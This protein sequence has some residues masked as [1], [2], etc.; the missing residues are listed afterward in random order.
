MRKSVIVAILVIAVLTLFFAA[1]NG[2]NS[3]TGLQTIDL[4][5]P[6]P[7][8]GMEAD[9]LVPSTPTPQ[10]AATPVPT[11][12]AMRADDTMNILRRLE[13][14]EQRLAGFLAWEQRLATV[15]AQIKIVSDP[16][17]R[18]DALQSQIDAMRV[19][20]E[21]LKQRPGLEAPFFDALSNL[22]GQQ[23]KNAILSIMLSVLALV[24][25][26]GMITAGIIHKKREEI[27]DKKLVRQYLHNYLQAGYRL[28]TLRMHLLA[29]GWDEKFIDERI[30][31]LPK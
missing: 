8:P 23:R 18:I 12:A 26:A 6:P 2:Y 20:I 30:K 11:P 7:P 19:D 16:S 31:E 28:E 22:Q 10:V 17:S 24:I 1:S 25:I 14:I 4:P 29:N 5:E 3:I 13:L 9:Q 21:N 27:E 15:E